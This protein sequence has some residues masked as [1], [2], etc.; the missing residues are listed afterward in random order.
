MYSYLPQLHKLFFG[1]TFSTTP[2]QQSLPQHRF[3]T[4]SIAPSFVT[5]LQHRLCDII[6]YGIAS[7][8]L[9]HFDFAIVFNYALMLQ[10]Y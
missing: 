8:L 4:T 6:F 2:F 10:Q 9:L 7:T 5:P 1:A 3:N